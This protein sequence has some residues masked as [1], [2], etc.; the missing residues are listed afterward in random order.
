MQR[1]YIYI[2]TFNPSPQL[3]KSQPS[4]SGRDL[5]DS[6][7]PLL[8][9]LADSGAGDHLIMSLIFTRRVKLHL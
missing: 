9:F 7:G 5:I 2:I 1:E 3:S 4:Y 6:L 8:Q